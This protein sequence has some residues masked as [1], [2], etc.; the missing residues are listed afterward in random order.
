MLAQSSYYH[1]LTKFKTLYI[2][3]TSTHITGP[4]LTVNLSHRLSIIQG[5]GSN[6]SLTDE[7]PYSESP[8]TSIGNCRYL[9]SFNCLQWFKY[10]NVQILLQ[11]VQVSH[12]TLHM[13]LC[14]LSN[15]LCVQHIWIPTDKFKIIGCPEPQLHSGL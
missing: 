12:K 11:R 1:V 5:V 8:R 7:T 14:V 13:H 4:Q 9:F 15:Q 2:N 3:T 10:Y 6:W